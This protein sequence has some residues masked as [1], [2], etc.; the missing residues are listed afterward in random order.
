[1]IRRTDPVIPT[2]MPGETTWPTP[3]PS[4]SPTPTPPPSASKAIMLKTPTVGS[5]ISA[6]RQNQV[7]N[8]I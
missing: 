6:A 2:M 3:V 8:D 7:S 1:M 4:P 5:T